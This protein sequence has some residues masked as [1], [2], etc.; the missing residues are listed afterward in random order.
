MSTSSNMTAA[1]NTT[2]GTP[3]AHSRIRISDT[4]DGHPSLS[5]ATERSD[6]SLEL[7]RH[8]REDLDKEDAEIDSQDNFDI[9]KNE[10]R[11]AGTLSKEF[12]DQEEIAVIKKLDRRLVL[13]LGFLYM[14]SFLDRSSK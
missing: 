7:R 3:S 4:A 12:T 5:S 10:L 1:E 8:R 6:R 11:R 13:F 14:L 9:D 2:S